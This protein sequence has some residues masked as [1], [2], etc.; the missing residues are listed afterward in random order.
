MDIRVD[1]LS[2]P[3]IAA[4]LTEHLQSLA[5][6]SP[7]ESCHALDLDGLRQPQITL[8]S[9]WQGQELVGCGALKELDAAHA[10]IKSMRTA[11]AHLRKG[12]GELLLQHLISEATNRGYRRMSLETGSMEYFEPARCLYLKFGFMT[13]A[14]F[15]NYREDPNS[16][17]MTK[18]L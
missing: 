6:V 4:L 3:E 11:S 1:D 18:E 8:W 10:E 13:C 15:A 17:F 9:V 12:V 16:V 2:G 5:E 14:P 7:P